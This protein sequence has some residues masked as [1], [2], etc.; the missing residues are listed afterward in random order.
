[1]ICDSTQTQPE[2]KLL[3]FLAIRHQQLFVY[4]EGALGYHR[5]QEIWLQSN[6]FWSYAIEN[7]DDNSRIWLKYGQTGNH[8]G[9]IQ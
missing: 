5:N 4:F 3:E 6:C 8:I 9:T 2:P 7:K 1:M